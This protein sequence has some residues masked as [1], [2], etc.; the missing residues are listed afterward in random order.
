MN[1]KLVYIAS[2]YKG[3]V[4]AN[5]EFARNACGYCMTANLYRPS[6]T[7]LSKLQTTRYATTALPSMNI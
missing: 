2:P 4:A 6:Q 3:D 5:T 1:K 7:V